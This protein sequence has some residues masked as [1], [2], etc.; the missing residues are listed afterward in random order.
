MDPLA[1]LDPLAL[2]ALTDIT[3]DI[4]MTTTDMVAFSIT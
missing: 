4:T 1:H 2:M 3:T